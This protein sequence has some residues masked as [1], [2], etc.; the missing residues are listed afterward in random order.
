LKLDDS[1]LSDSMEYLISTPHC[2]FAENP[3]TS[4][5]LDRM[6]DDVLSH[7]QR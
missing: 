6:G 4:S 3:P 2:L 5:D 7:L 1:P